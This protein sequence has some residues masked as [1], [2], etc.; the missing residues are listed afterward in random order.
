MCIQARKSHRERET[1]YGCC[2]YRL[3]FDFGGCN[4]LNVVNDWCYVGRFGGIEDGGGFNQPR[5]CPWSVAFKTG[6]HG[7][8][9]R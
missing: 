9:K 8:G 1:E 4:R 5:T 3:G 2:R 7:V 6:V